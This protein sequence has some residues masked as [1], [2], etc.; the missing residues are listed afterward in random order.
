MENWLDFCGTTKNKKNINTGNVRGGK[1]KGHGKR[2]LKRVVKTKK[3]TPLT[4]E[5]KVIEAARP[6]LYGKN[7]WETGDLRQGYN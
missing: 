5:R 1:S 2:S 6:G 3:K 4:K 7:G